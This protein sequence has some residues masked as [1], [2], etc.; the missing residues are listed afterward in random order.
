MLVLTQS[1]LLHFNAGMIFHINVQ[2]KIELYGSA[3]TTLTPKVLVEV[4]V[5]PHQSY[6]YLHCGREV[7][8][9]L[10]Y[11]IFQGEDIKSP[12]KG[13]QKSLNNVLLLIFYVS[14]LKLLAVTVKI[15]E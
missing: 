12:N 7:V 3:M 15:C 10:L 5:C 6:Q 14:V 2:W 9:Y 13:K 4:C 11:D 1:L 8:Y